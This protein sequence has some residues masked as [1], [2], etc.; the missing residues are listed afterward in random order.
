MP[1]QGK[2]KTVE[3]PAT[4][5]GKGSSGTAILKKLFKTSPLYGGNPTLNI[6]TREKLVALAKLKLTPSVQNG[7]PMLYPS[8]SLD[9][10]DA[11]DVPNIQVNA[12]GGDPSTPWS[13]NLNSPGEG[14][15][16]DPTKVTAMDPEAIPVP[17]G[18][19]V[20]GQGGL[21]NPKTTSA[22]DASTELGEALPLGSHPKP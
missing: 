7:D 22:E 5:Y 9:Y 18:D 2:Y 1:G 12:G 8:V 19:N 20:V 21:V 13:P 4:E 15:G 17:S 11:P 14:N 16:A 10:V 6:E 3:V